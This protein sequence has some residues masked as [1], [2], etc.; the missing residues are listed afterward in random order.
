VV[1]SLKEAGFEYI[2]SGTA[3]VLKPAE[4][5]SA[6]ED[7]WAAI[8]DVALPVEALNVFIPPHL[9]IT[10]ESPDTATVVHYATTALTRAGQ[11]GIPVIVFGS[12]GA[13]AV[14]EGFSHAV[15]TQ[16]IEDFLKELAPV[17]LENRV[18]ITVEPLRVPECNIL[19]TVAE[20]AAMVR[21]IEHPAIR[22]LVDAYHWYSNDNDA[23]SIADSGDLL[24][25]AHIATLPNR[26]APGHE[27]FDFAPFIAALRA[28]R[29]NA[30]LSIEANVLETP[31]D[32]QIAHRAMS[33]IVTD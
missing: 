21:R 4:S 3:A 33:S 6:F 27:P 14:P 18:T 25:H 32:F 5:Q 10:G 11:A 17:A 26:M 1:S 30:R 2:E 7:G 24:R 29:Y 16:Q 28:A 31:E 13:R 19:V 20:A 23:Q 12:G 15:A 8:R 9:K 22:L